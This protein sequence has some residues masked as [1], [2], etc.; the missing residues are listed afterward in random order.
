MSST[1]HSCSPD[2]RG[3]P[4]RTGKAVHCVDYVIRT[5]GIKPIGRAGHAK[6]YAESDVAFIASELRRIDEEREEGN[7]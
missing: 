4:R 5:R 7:G 6:I 1:Y 2:C 3:D